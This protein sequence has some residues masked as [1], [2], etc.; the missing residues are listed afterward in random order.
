MCRWL[1]QIQ[2]S[3]F[4]RTSHTSWCSHNIKKT[5]AEHA[6]EWNSQS[7]FSH[8]SLEFLICSLK[9]FWHVSYS[10]NFSGFPRQKNSAPSPVE[11]KQ[12]LWCCVGGRVDY[13]W[14]SPLSTRLQLLARPVARQLRRILKMML[15]GYEPE[16]TTI[17]TNSLLE[18]RRC[19]FKKWLGENSTR[20]R[21]FR[22]TVGLRASYTYGL[23]G[24]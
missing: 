18:R 13:S 16:T 4:P 24:W 12:K 1:V 7:L 19:L 9:I 3:T 23:K 22:Y 11:K 17:P 5:A 20:T 2:G 10:S 8:D 6:W 15:S 14:R 21:A